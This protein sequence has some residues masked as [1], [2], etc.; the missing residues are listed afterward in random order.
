[1][2]AVHCVRLLR[3]LLV[4][5]RDEPLAA[6]SPL[7][8]LDLDAVLDF[9]GAHAAVR[10]AAVWHLSSIVNRLLAYPVRRRSR[11][12]FRLGVEVL[13]VIADALGAVDLAVF[14]DLL[15]QLPV[16]FCSRVERG[17]TLIGLAASAQW[18]LV[19]VQ[20]QCRPKIVLNV[21]TTNV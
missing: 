14:G 13:G 20:I 19:F 18:S 5:D 17:R 9:L 2:S 8:L 3:L 16:H 15:L 12:L 7:S 4:D 21:L 10:F 11:I 1:M 6:V